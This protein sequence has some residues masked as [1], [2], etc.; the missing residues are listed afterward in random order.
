MTAPASTSAVLPPKGTPAR[1][2]ALGFITLAPLF[3]GVLS[4]WLGQDA[5]WDL[6]NYH[7]YNAWALWTGRYAS[8]IDFLPSQG[9]FFHN[10]TLDIPF[11]LLA[12]AL[13]LQLAFFILS[14][15]QGLNITLLFLLAHLSLDIQDAKRKVLAAAALALL[16]F[17]GGMGISEIGTLFYDNVTSLGIFLSALLVLV[18]FERLRTAPLKDIAHL[19]FFFGIPAGLAAGLKLTT[20]SFC[21]GLCFAMLVAPQNLKRGFWLAF[22]LGCGIMLGFVAGFGHWAWYLFAH[23]DSPTFPY[24]NKFF[25]S[26]L[27]PPQNFKDFYVPPGWRWA[28]PY[29][30]AVDPYLVNEIPWRDWRVPALYTLI[31]VAVTGV[32]VSGRRG[33]GGQISADR[34]AAFLLWMTSAAYVAWVSLQAVYR[35]ILPIEMLAPLLIVFCIDLLPVERKTRATFAAALLAALALAIQPGDWGRRDGWTSAV[36]DITPPVMKPS[37]M[38]LMASE[39]A[40]AFLLPQFPPETPFLRI[41]SRAFHSDKGIGI[42]KLIQAKLDAH[43]GPLMIFYPARRQK[44]AEKAL[45]DYGLRVNGKC[46]EIKDRLYAPELDKRLKGDE[47]PALYNLCPV[48]KQAAPRKKR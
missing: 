44:G 39:D 8:G 41:H 12:T 26:P 43:E 1:R 27:A 9:Q 40:Y 15:V 2:L 48:A 5:N 20:A 25:Q 4:M 6:R 31:W 47:Y 16:G 42:N 35:Y 11:Y 29:R 14:C 22:F 34:P 18:N 21:I 37:T 23:F 38:V 19:V 36:A 3:T 30:M 24:F 17:F 13:P 32:L 33:K 28:V 46:Q 45:A 7:W 10:P